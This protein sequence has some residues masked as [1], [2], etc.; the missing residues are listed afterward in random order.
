MIYV[1]WEFTVS[2][3]LIVAFEE[4]YRPDGIWAELFRRD[5]AY[6]ETILL[7]DFAQA[8]RY[9]TI[10]VWENRESYSGFKERFAAEYRR[11]DEQCERLT[12]S[13]RLIGM[14]TAVV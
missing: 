12:S 3:E 5:S 10:D 11:I 6:R 7:R 8:G 1:V 2:P 4:A 13:E 9:L 14:F